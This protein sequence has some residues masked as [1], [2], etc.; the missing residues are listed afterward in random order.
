MYTVQICRY[1]IDR[2]CWS[3]MSLVH[4]QVGAKPVSAKPSEVANPLTRYIYIELAY[5][6]ALIVP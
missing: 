1:L 5:C 4:F 2:F 6:G 3:T